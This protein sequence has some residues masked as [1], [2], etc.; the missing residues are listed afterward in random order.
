MAS[1]GGGAYNLTYEVG[2]LVHTDAREEGD[3]CSQPVTRR[4]DGEHDGTGWQRRVRR[5][6]TLAPGGGLGE[7]WEGRRSNPRL[8]C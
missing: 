3:R 2:V 5:D 7:P 1:E 6:W 4:R 8:E